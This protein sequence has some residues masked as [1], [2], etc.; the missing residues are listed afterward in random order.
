MVKM[1]IK[2]ISSIAQSAGSFSFLG[3]TQVTYPK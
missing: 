3:M 1:E 2:V